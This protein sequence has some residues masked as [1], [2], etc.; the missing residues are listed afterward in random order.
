MKLEQG[1]L[2]RELIF[3]LSIQ[4]ESFI[5]SNIFTNVEEDFKVNSFMTESLSYRNQ[6]NDLLCID[7]A[8]ALVSIW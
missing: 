7:F 5:T 4:N 2:Y 6:S 3:I 1:Y 8:L